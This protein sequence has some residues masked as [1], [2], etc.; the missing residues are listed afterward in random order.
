MTQL[1]YAAGD[2]SVPLLE[3]TIDANLRATVAAHGDREALV[4]R[5]QGIRWTYA[6][7]DARVD[8]LAQHGLQLGRFGRGAWA[9]ERSDDTTGHARSVEDRRQQRRA[10]RYY[11]HT[12]GVP[13]D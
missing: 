6:E 12:C 8:E 11:S 1:S 7:L 5:H 3:Q 2:T 13:R 10:Q 9:V 4:G